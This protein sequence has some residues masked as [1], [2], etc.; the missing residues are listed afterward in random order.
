MTRRKFRMKRRKRRE[1]SVK[2]IIY[3]HYV[4]FD[5]GLLTT[6]ERVK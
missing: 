2:P 4:V 6:G 1:N 5:E 3:I